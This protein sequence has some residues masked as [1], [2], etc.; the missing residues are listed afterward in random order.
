L[1][2][3]RWPQGFVV[4][5]IDRGTNQSKPRRKR[6]KYLDTRSGRIRLAAI[7]DNS[8]AS[9][10]AFV[11]ANVKTGTTLLTDGHRLTQLGLD[12]ADDAAGDLVMQLEN[13]LERAV[14]TACPN[15]RASRRV[16]QLAGDAHA[17]PR[18]AHAALEN[19][20]YAELA[21]DLAEVG[22]FSFVGEARI[23]RDHEQPRQPGDRR[24]DLLDDAVDKVFLLRVATHIGEGQNRNRRLVGKGKRRTYSRGSGHPGLASDPVCLDR[25]VDILH[26]LR[27]E[28]AAMRWARR[29][30]NQAATACDGA[31]Q[32]HIDRFMRNKPGFFN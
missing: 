4:E 25:L 10:E 11:R 27:A 29:A 31:M 22:R 17:A 8:A 19:I 9:I 5:V 14:E 21:A 7:P 32:A 18:F 13:V 30:P 26:L 23:A 24:G 3:R 12:R 28:I 6:A 16:D 2:E 1:F 15:M 20:A